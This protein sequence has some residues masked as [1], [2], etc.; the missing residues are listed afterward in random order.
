MMRMVQ[1]S[2]FVN[3][4]IIMILELVATRVLAP[5]AGTTMEVWSAVIGVMLAAVGVGYS[6]GGV[7]ADKR[8]SLA[9]LALFFAL[10]GCSVVF[11]V[12]MDGVLLPAITR[13]VFYGLDA[14]LGAV[15]TYTIRLGVR[16]VDSL[17]ETNGMLY[18]LSTLGSLLGVFG[19]SLYL[20]PTYHVST[21]LYGVSGGLLLMA[22]FCFGLYAFSPRIKR[23]P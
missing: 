16:G 7:L 19:T 21:I 12:F 14:F 17:G 4:A 23:N 3:G 5:Y 1:F 11:I 18:A 10:A 22:T 20:V 9:T 13:N 2:V 6:L 8:R 15:T